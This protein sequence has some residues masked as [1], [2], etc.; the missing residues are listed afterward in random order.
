MLEKRNY[1]ALLK[2]FYGPLLTDKQQNILDLYY[3]DDLSLSEIA[4]NLAISRQAVYDILK[5]AEQVLEGYEQKLGLVKRFQDS[6]ARIKEIYNIL[7]SK[8][9][10]R[11][12]LKRIKE[13]LESISE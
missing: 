2:D 6:R 12:S 9:F 8:Q 3:G 4:E 5:R 11:S 10:D 1:I 7:D 13:I